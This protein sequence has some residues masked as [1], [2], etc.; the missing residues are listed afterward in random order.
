M[1]KRLIKP[2]LIILAFVFAGGAAVAREG[3]CARCDLTAGVM[4]VKCH[5]RYPLKATLCIDDIVAFIS[6][7]EEEGRICRPLEPTSQDEKFDVSKVVEA[8]NLQAKARPEAEAVEVAYQ[9]LADDY[10]CN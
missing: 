10:P 5:N 2:V 1:I 3:D 7:L 9:A 6:Y 4:D 8:I